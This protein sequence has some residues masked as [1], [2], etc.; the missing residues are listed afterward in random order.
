MN[1]LSALEDQILAID[2][3]PDSRP[4]APA[5]S[6]ADVDML[7][8]RVQG[9][10]SGQDRVRLEVEGIRD[11]WTAATTGTQETAVGAHPFSGAGWGQLTCRPSSAG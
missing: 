10:E 8:Q 9:L 3:A 5:L 11:D 7:L 2:V 6:S 4:N 1:R